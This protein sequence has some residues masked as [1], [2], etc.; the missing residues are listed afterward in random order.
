M[1]TYGLRMKEV[2]FFVIVVHAGRLSVKK[3]NSGAG[4]T[5]FIRKSHSY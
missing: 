3:A 4:D 5:K 2:S 1:F